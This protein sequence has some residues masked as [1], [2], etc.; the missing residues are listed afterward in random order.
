ML[1]KIGTYSLLGAS[2]IPEPEL[3]VRMMHY[4][5]RRDTFC[6]QQAYQMLRDSRRHNRLNDLLGCFA[7]KQTEVT[8]GR[9]HVAG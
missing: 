4:L 7:L 3:P 8:Q 2:S 5:L 9:E 1:L 6:L